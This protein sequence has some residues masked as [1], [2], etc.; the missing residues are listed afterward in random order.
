[1][2]S[3]QK[4]K[5]FYDLLKDFSKKDLI[6]PLFL[7]SLFNNEIAY[8]ADGRIIYN[9]PQRPDN[10]DDKKSKLN[11]NLT[12]SQATKNLGINRIYDCGKIKFEKVIYR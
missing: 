10:L 7:S 2:F 1:M 6:E 11:T 5:D 12:E 9:A 3:F 8:S 4:N